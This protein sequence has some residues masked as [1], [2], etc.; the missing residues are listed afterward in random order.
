M[1]TSQTAM[2]APDG[3][4]PEL[5]RSGMRPIG[6]LL[7]ESGKLASD[8]IEMVRR[9]QQA[10]DSLFGEAAVKLGLVSQ[11][12]VDTAV[13]RQFSLNRLV[14]GDSNVSDEVFAAYRPEAREAESLRRLRNNLVLGYFSRNAD[15]RMLAVT[16]AHAGDGRSVVAANLAVLFAQTGR[17]TLLIDAD[18]HNPRQ[19]KLFGITNRKGLSGIL[20]GTNSSEVI[21][22][23]ASIGE[24]YVLHAGVTP[25]NPQELIGRDIFKLLLDNLSRQ[26][27]VILLDTPPMDEYS[28]AQ[29]IAG[30]AGAALFVVRNNVGRVAAMRRSVDDLVKADVDVVGSFLN[31][32]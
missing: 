8:K 26:F 27:D 20:A 13:S 29:V 10:D 16:S 3:N 21:E 14:A 5:P 24:M 2:M 17:R 25:P 4:R 28:D 31:N 12:D 23:I 19:H 18:L 6:T 32:Y 7:V 9:R 15:S 22:N 11:R 1:S 30:A